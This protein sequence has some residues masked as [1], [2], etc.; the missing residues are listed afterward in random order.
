MLES[1]KIDDKVAKEA[2]HED[3][4]ALSQFVHNE[5]ASTRS[6]APS[7]IDQFKAITVE[8]L[9]D[10]PAGVLHALQHPGALIENGLISAGIGFAGKILLPEA[11]PLGKVAAIGLGAYFTEQMAAPIVHSYKKGF[12]TGDVQSAGRELGDS[13][14]GLAVNLPVGIYGFGVGAGLGSKVMISESMSGFA[15]LKG[16]VLNP[17]NDALSNLLHGKTGFAE[18]PQLATIPGSNRGE[19]T[20]FARNA[21]TQEHSVPGG[22]GIIPPY[23]FEELTRRNPA[24]KDFLKTYEKTNDLINT[25]GV[26]RPRTDG[27]YHGAREVYDAKGKEVQ[28]GDK[29]RFEGEKPTGNVEVDN[30]YDFA[31]LVR[32]FYQ[33]EYNRNSIDGKGMKFKSTVNYGQ[34]YE[35]AFWNGSQMTYGR[36]GPDSPFKTFALLDVSGHEITHGVTEMESNLRYRGQSGALNESLSDVYGELVKQYGSHQTADQANWLV[37]DGIWKDGI[38]GK[39]LRD[40]LN[41]GTAYDDPKVGKDPQP[42]HMKD[43]V[44][45]YGDNG[46]V[47]Y[48]SGIPNKAF[49]LFAKAVGGNAW[50]DPGHIWFAARKA[51]GSDPSFAQFAYHTIEQA[52]NL[53]HENE[54]AVLQKAWEDVGVTP[55]KTAVDT[56]TPGSDTSDSGL[57]LAKAPKVVDGGKDSSALRNVI[58]FI[59]L[60]QSGEQKTGT[61][62]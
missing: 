50:D 58:P 15:D 38:K 3:K 9:K 59:N 18:T 43:Y 5:A 56:S 23:M 49:A 19:V 26:A 62:G 28:P 55:S 51:A 17:V 39:A 31:G 1:S 11:G 33:K 40:M 7:K 34:N 25:T 47:H 6:A 53:G 14:G 20:A 21:A 16:R 24:N 4:V 61:E 30:V 60:N 48:N 45:T 13:V 57:S 12:Q 2:V 44:D 42:G 35:N 41:P 22:Y 27:D 52:K 10:T 36:P 54:V 32:D 8:G 29:A 46:G 37:G